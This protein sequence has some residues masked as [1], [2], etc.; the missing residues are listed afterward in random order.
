MMRMI[1][2]SRR[3]KENDVLEDY[4]TWLKRSTREA[5]EKM[6]EHGIMDWVEEAHRRKF[7]WAGKT[8]RCEDGRWS[9]K[10]L[11][12]S[13]AG[14]RAQGRPQTRWADCLNKFFEGDSQNEVWTTLAQDE[15]FWEEME[16]NYINWIMQ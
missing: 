2:G 14:H 15:Q 7:K 3:R 13:V 1:L 9:K 11:S 5:E 4:I 16:K 10:L 12:W 6:K 8:A